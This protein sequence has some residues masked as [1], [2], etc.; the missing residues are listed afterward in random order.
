MLFFIQMKNTVARRII[1]MCIDLGLIAGYLYAMDWALWFIDLSDGLLV[2]SVFV[3]GLLVPIQ[4]ALWGKTI[5]KRIMGLQLQKAD[6]SKIGFGRAFLRY[7]IR[8]LLIPLSPIS[9]WLLAKKN[10]N[11]TDY[12][13]QT[14]VVPIAK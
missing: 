6:G 10:K 13:M 12:L 11:L 5:G 3:I 1:A 2:L 4:E 8:V 9:L 7:H 14:Q